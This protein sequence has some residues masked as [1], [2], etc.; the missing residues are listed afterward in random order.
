MTE[1]WMDLKGYNGKYQVSDKG[2]VWSC[3]RNRIL[4]P[5]IDKDGYE[6]YCLT[7]PQGKRKYERGHRL[8][9]LMF[10]EKPD[11]YNVV[12]HKNMIKDDNR[13]ENLEWSTVALNTKHAYHKSEAIRKRTTEASRLGADKT[14]MT[15]KVTRHG[16]LVGF[17]EGQEQCAKELGISKKTIY[18]AVNSNMENRKGYAFEVVEVMPCQVKSVSS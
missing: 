10:C 4:K 6:E 12:N 17:F 9:A 11:G 14:R 5:K 8:V 16:E 2:R 13:A 3:Y 7:L 18:N 15:L 1:I